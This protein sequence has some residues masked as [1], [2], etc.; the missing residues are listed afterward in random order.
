MKFFIEV[1]TQDVQDGDELQKDM[2]ILLKELFD[3]KT[4][5]DIDSIGPTYYLVAR[6]LEEFDSMYDIFTRLSRKGGCHISQGSCN[7]DKETLIDMKMEEEENLEDAVFY[8]F[9]EH[10]YID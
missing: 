9:R 3:M 4:F 1:S 5:N 10:N 8:E 6:T 7:I 2:S